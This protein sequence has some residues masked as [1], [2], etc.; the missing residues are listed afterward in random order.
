MAMFIVANLVGSTIQITTLPLPVL[1]TL[2][3]SGLVFNTICATLLLGEPFTRWSFGGTALVAG[4]AVLIALFGALPEPSHT[5]DQLL[6]LLVRPQFV[7][8]MFCTAVAIVGILALALVLPNIR[9]SR[10]S[11]HDRASDSVHIH[12]LTPRVRFVLGLSYGGI[13]AILSSHSL[14]VAKSAVELLIQTLAHGNN[15]FNRWQSW[16][17]LLALLFLALSQLY[18]LHRGLKIVSTSVLYP[19]VFCIYNVIAI[20]DGLIYFHQTDRLPP[21]HAGL[22]ALGTVILLA[23]V[24]ALSWRLSDESQQESLHGHGHHHTPVIGQES[25]L[26][27]GMGMMEDVTTGSPTPGSSYCTSPDAYASDEGEDE[28]DLVLDQVRN[29]KAS[30]ERT[31]LLAKGRPERR[32][33]SGSNRRRH[34]HSISDTTDSENIWDALMDISTKEA[35]ERHTWGLHRGRRASTMTALGRPRETEAANLNVG[36]E[37]EDDRPLGRQR[38]TRTVAVTDGRWQDTEEAPRSVSGPL[39]HR[40]RSSRQRRRREGSLGAWFGGLF[41]INRRGETE[42]NREAF[43]PEEGH[44]RGAEG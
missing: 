19:F 36:N 8:W 41:G 40:T 25:L 26:T 43:V 17:I 15:Q 11:G 38:R 34:S 5:L 1:S 7:A 33:K 4:G 39:P 10:R 6:A 24:L 28:N 14:L 9:S 29:G 44:D 12:R 13:S 2:Q 16:I 18:F 35:L 20:L 32:R 31:P 30:S 23:G 3:A 22:I 21:L 42:R 27:P 37:N